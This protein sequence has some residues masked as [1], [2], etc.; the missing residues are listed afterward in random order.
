MPT[1]T[2]YEINGFAVREL[3][4]RSGLSPVELAAAIKVQ[5]AY[6]ARI[7]LGHSRRVSMRVFNALIAAL[8]IEDRRVLLANPYGDELPAAAGQ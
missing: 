8:S 3:R 1:A 7:E 5:R 6:V 2:T 4:K